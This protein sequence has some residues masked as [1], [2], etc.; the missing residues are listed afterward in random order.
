[1]K[2]EGSH[3]FP[4]APQGL[5]DIL[6]DPA[7][8]ARAIPGCEG[9]RPTGPDE[10]EATLRIGVAAVRGTYV[11]KVRIADKAPP[12]HYRLLAEGSGTPGFVKGNALI[13]LEPD[14]AGTRMVV[15]GE[16][17]VGGLIAGVGQR[18][19][20]GVAKM[21]LDQFFKGI[22]GLL[23]APAVAAAEPQAPAAAEAPGA[24]AK[25]EGVI[26]RIVKAILRWLRRG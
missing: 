19:L 10:F 13:R 23:P 9:L 18:M 4:I 5:W 6:S 16:A 22:E 1:M 14:G 24:S 26:A 17:E 7:A 20:G 2:V 11:G 21:M 3:P 12:S 15:S 8:L 25:P